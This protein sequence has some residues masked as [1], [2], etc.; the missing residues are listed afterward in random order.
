M[1]YYLKLHGHHCRPLLP[2]LIGMALLLNVLRRH[3]LLPGRQGGEVS[4]T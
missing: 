1:E 3:H 2:G 4:L